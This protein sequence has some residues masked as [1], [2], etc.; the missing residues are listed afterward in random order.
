MKAVVYHQYGQPDVLRI[1]EVA[2]PKPK[3][4]HTR[5]RVHAAALNP[6]DILVRKGK[7][8]WLVGRALPRTPGYDFAGV[9]LDDLPGLPAGS[10]VFGMIQ[11]HKAGGCA[12]MVRVS[13]Q[14]LAIKPSALTM[15]E[16][17]SLPLAALTALQAL[18]DELCVQPGE[19]ILLNGASGGVGTM[20]VQIANQL[21][22]HT[23]AVCSSRNRELVT[24]LGANE[25]LD[26][27][28]RDVLDVR[29]LDVFFDIFGNYPWP[30]PVKTL[31][32]GGRFCST[33]PSP[34]AITY[35]VLKRL[36][37]HRA[38][39]VVVQ[40][41]SKDLRQLASWVDSGALR[42]V[43]DRVFEMEQTQ[44]AHAY[45]ETKRARGK[46]VLTIPQ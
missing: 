5:V 2:E 4:G 32:G 25:V 10:E 38:A 29:D 12:Q 1:E 9:T 21:G 6:K 39:L 11:S 3:R 41:R 33:V 28:E 18:R 8:K 40:S 27:T 31:R 34:G 22:A 19:R 44:Q 17:A 15:A 45:I 35:G 7:M 23:I 46:V 14:E 36:K 13:G 20:A 24:S 26:Y 16:A 30:K 37:L 43:V 42:P